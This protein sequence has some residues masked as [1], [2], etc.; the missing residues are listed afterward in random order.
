M[1]P[2]E[3]AQAMEALVTRIANME[4]SYDDPDNGTFCVLCMAQYK[5]ANIGGTVCFTVAH[6]P[7]CDYIAA[8]T[9]I[10]LE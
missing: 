1:T 7:D 8:R 4:P 3:R 6:T 2:E 10:G 5:Y 9:L